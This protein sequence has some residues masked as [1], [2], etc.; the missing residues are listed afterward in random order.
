MNFWFV[1]C[2]PYV[3]EIPELNELVHKYQDDEVVFLGFSTNKK[4]KIN[5]FIKEKEFH[6][7][8]IPESRNIASDYNVSGYPS[9]IVIYRNSKI[10]YT[11]TGLGPT[12]IKDLENMIKSLK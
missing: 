8:L 12:T 6:Y 7:N 5:S 4:D 10:V 9:H 1:E 3:Q 2:K 11:T